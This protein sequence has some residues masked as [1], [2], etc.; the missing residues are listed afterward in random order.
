MLGILANVASPLDFN[1]LGIACAIHFQQC[2]DEMN[3]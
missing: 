2:L 1:D 3:K